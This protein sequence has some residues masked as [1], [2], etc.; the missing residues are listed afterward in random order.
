MWARWCRIPFMVIREVYLGYEKVF[1]AWQDQ[2]LQAGSV[3]E[4]VVVGMSEGCESCDGVQDRWV[5]VLRN[6]QEKRQFDVG[7]VIVKKCQEAVRKGNGSFPR[8]CK[9]LGPAALSIATR[10]LSSGSVVPRSL[11]RPQS[12]K[13]RTPPPRKPPDTNRCI[14][15]DALGY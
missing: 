13:T 5:M 2:L 10:V 14:Q 8:W 12:T 15:T 4:E 1:L 3:F 9:C 11:P 6:W 7:V